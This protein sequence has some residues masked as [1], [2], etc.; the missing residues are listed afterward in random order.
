MT[1]QIL[2]PH[3]QA[4]GTSGTH[5]RSPDD[6][7]RKIRKSSV[8]EQKT[9][10]NQAQPARAQSQGAAHELD[11]SQQQ[12]HMGPGHGEDVNQSG[13]AERF[14]QAWRQFIVMTAEEQTSKHRRIGFAE[15]SLIPPGQCLAQGL[16]KRVP[17]TRWSRHGH[18]FPIIG[19]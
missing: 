7:R 2:A 16:Q 4:Q 5:E 17:A 9:H 10:R 11:D 6:R 1:G 12:C 3:S 19:K 13:R 8:Q 15:D 14:Q 18:L